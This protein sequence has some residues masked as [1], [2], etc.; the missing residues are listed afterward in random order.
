MDSNKYR[1]KLHRYHQDRT[2]IT[3]EEAKGFK[4]AQIPGCGTPNSLYKRYVYLKDNDLDQIRAIKFCPDCKDLL[5]KTRSCIK[6]DKT[7]QPSC[8]NR[9]TCVSCLD[10][11]K[12]QHND[13]G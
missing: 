2:L 4:S 8:N 13:Q 7:F 5:G 10:W 11:Q 9:F 1:N 3:E 6:C 12:G